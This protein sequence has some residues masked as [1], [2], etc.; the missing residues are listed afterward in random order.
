MILPFAVGGDDALGTTGPY[1]LAGDGYPRRMPLKL[2]A[3]AKSSLVGSRLRNDYGLTKDRRGPE[4]LRNPGRFGDEAAADEV[5]NQTIREP[6]HRRKPT[7][8]SAGI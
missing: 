4:A 5:L 8:P 6:A 3:R 1:A 2:E 7:P